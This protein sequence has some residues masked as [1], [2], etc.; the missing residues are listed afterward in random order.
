MHI[1]ILELAPSKKKTMSLFLQKN[2]KN[3]IIIFSQLSARLYEN[4][5][6]SFILFRKKGKKTFFQKKKGEETNE[7]SRL[8]N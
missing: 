7:V 6:I 1:L 3:S 5:F 4:Q 8:T 2:N